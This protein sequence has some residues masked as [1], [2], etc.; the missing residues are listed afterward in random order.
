MN[1]FNEMFVY[2]LD[3]SYD[4]LQ[5]ANCPYIYSAVKF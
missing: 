4:I 2:T 5:T 3:K 1:S